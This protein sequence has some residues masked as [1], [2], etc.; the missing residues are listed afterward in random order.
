MDKNIRNT[1]KT[2]GYK[3]VTFLCLVAVVFSLLVVFEPSTAFATSSGEYSNVLDDLKKDESFDIANYPEKSDDYSLQLVQIAESTNE[4]FVYVYQPSGKIK[5][6]R[7][8]SINI[9]TSIGDDVKFKNYS[10][11][12]CNSFGTLYKYVVEG[13]TLVN[14]PTRYYSI[15]EILR[16][17]EEGIDEPATGD[18]VISEVPYKV[19]K[20]YEFSMLNG[21]PFN[22]VKDIEVIEITDKFVGFVRY[23]KGYHL[24]NSSCDS[25]FVAF[26]TDKPIDTLLEADVEYKQQHY[27]YHYN[28][29]N[30]FDP[31]EE[32]YGAILDKEVPLTH[33]DYGSMVGGGIFQNQPYSWKRID[34]VENFLK[35]ET[36][37]SIYEIG[38]FNVKTHR[39]LTDE[40]KA[41]LQG[42][43]WILRFVDTEYYYQ[44]NTN[45]EEKYYWDTVG[46]VMILRL[47]FVTDGV[48]YNLGTIDNKQTGSGSP[49]GGSA[50]SDIEL[51]D[52][53]KAALFILVIIILIILLWPVMP[54]VIQFVFWLVSLPFKLIGAIFGG[55]K[56]LANRSK[57]RPTQNKSKA[58]H[59]NEKNVTKKG[60]YK[61]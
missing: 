8:S 19:A 53:G 34:T 59:V 44:R 3:F 25:H 42:K 61:R 43:K 39:K 52:K 23:T 58:V 28:P 37:S 11:K 45:G 57:E 10:L 40:G 6:L 47:K 32:R 26:N 36:G 54:Y 50:G 30:T 41:N 48:T 17:W 5:D 33:N 14:Q 12:Y 20:I 18:N 55:F 27:F 56:K 29:T 15:T 13:F 49:I 38:L 1:N 51:N 7:A 22:R 35:T 16:P 2:L 21:K 9:S 60:K 4:L 46:D 24:F 31:I